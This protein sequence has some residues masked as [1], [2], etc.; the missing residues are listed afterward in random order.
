MIILNPTDEAIRARLR[1]R[2]AERGFTSDEKIEPHVGYNQWFRRNRGKFPLVIDNTN[3]TVGETAK[4]IEE[5]V[6]RFA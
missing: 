6:K 1:A 5:F 3:Q 2:P 4:I